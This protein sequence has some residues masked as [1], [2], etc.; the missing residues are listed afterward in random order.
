MATTAS[1]KQQCP[2]CET[3][4]PIRDPNL[5]GR[6]IDCPKCKYRFVVEDPGTDAEAEEVAE[7][8][9]KKR[10]GRRDPE[11]E[12]TPARGSRRRREADDEGGEGAKGGMSPKVLMLVGGGVLAVILLVVVGIFM[13]GGGSDTKKTTST[14][15]TT[16]VAS[17][18]SDNED[19]PAVKS[20]ASVSS[21]FITNL[22][23]PD[24][25]AVVNLR[26]HELIRTELGRAFFDTPGA[27]RNA[28]LQ[29]RLGFSVDDV[30]RLVQALSFS[31][32]WAFNVLHT[33]NPINKEAVKKA[34]HAAPAG[35]IQNIEYFVLGPN[36]WLDELGRVSFA[37]LL[38]VDPARVPAR[39]GK[40]LLRIK[41]D[42]TLV[43]GGEEP[44][45]AFLNL[46]EVFPAHKPPAP[47]AQPKEESAQ[48][49]AGPGPGRMGMGG[50]GPQMGA[51]G[52]MGPGG[53]PNQPNQQESG[54]NAEEKASEAL[55]SGS[56]LSVDP[57]LKAML[58]RVE[59][60]QA[61][62][63]M[64]LDTRAIGERLPWFNLNNYKVVGLI[65][66][67]ITDAG[68]FGASL[69]LRDGV[70]FTAAADYQSEETALKRE[71]V[72]KD[73]APLLASA[74]GQALSV[75]TE[76][77]EESAE[78][79]NL[80]GPGGRG[81]LPGMMGGMGPRGAAGMAGG[82]F[83]GALMPGGAG[84]QM[85][86]MRGPGGGNTRQSMQQGMMA[87][88]Q[89][90]MAQMGRRGGMPGMQGPP[91]MPGFPGMQQN[92]AQEPPK[93]KPGATVY[94]TYPDK[95]LAV[96][97]VTITDAAAN[98][99][100]TNETVR[101]LVLEEKGYL[102]M[103]GGALRIFDV[104]KAAR[105]YAES[106]QM[107]FP[108]GTVE[109]KVPTSRAGRPYAPDQRLS[110]MTELLPFLGE[111]QASLYQRLDREKSWNDPE[112]LLSAVTL[113]PQFLDPR[114]PVK[115]WW[116]PYPGLDQRVAA[117]HYV[118]I[119]G[120]GLDAA[121]YASGDGAV[122]G[123]LGIFGYDRETRV[124]DIK[125]GSANTILMAEVPPTFKRPWLAGGGSTVV[126]VPEKDSIKPFVSTQRDGKPGTMVLM[127]DGSV[128]FI[129]ANVSDD[130]FKAM[131]TIQ[132]GEAVNVRREAPVIPEPSP[133]QDEPAPAPAPAKK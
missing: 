39:V 41:D 37:T 30:D 46:K 11:D 64:V 44:M 9:P 7:E 19:K 13:F 56:Y 116:V 50:R 22:L 49:Q 78:Q 25:E 23:P 43:F 4:V 74:I 99:K 79:P 89:G 98:A 127:A 128:R 86:G 96:M 131:C 20:V 33:R 91:G 109:R 117:T 110:W 81:P 76:S 120:I 87:M 119:A 90:M 130:V 68:I 100:F 16:P 122:A 28:A 8:A 115:T 51:M 47:K 67:L 15:T 94:Y 53:R 112:N 111:E 42:R 18:P 85:P 61:V 126:G 103:A 34:L 125:D 35:K 73:T 75:K 55:T 95:T 26:M 132:G 32:N 106:H 108:R 72:F 59:K 21:E 107:T 121:N 70:L 118:G 113:I 114:N 60:K 84:G 101:S 93:E 3:W 69:Q 92:N 17:S 14:A 62:A 2:S 27:F 45:K 40:E 52:G 1:F 38:Q 83:G 88:Q 54:D 6:K 77:G 31:H 123:K 58:D 104:G 80:N 129:A 66:T 24:T 133:D 102:D 36:P 65:R 105:S 48:Q 82:K 63:T 12:E 29:Q 71:N 97:I 124:Q 5:I 10:K 57:A